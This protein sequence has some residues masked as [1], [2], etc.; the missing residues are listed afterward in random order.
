MGPKQGNYCYTLISLICLALFITISPVSPTSGQNSMVIE[1]KTNETQRISILVGKSSDTD[2][3]PM[4]DGDP[5]AEG[6][7]DGN[8]VDQAP[9]TG[10]DYCQMGNRCCYQFT[11]QGYVQEVPT[12]AANTTCEYLRAE[13]KAPDMACFDPIV[14][15]RPD[16]GSNIA[17]GRGPDVVRLRN[18]AQENNW[19]IFCPLT[20]DKICLTLKYFSRGAGNQVANETRFC[21]SV[22]ETITGQK[23]SSGCWKENAPG[24]IREVCA[25]TNSLCN[26]GSPR[27]LGSSSLSWLLVVVSLI[28]RMISSQ[29]DV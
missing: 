25:C 18:D 27:S 9:S 10:W 14:Y 21:G 11:W 22:T 20:D 1:S 16:E 23:K 4:A 28:L 29:S 6:D 5:P 24:Y 26:T 7:E 19:N 15:T 8:I 13:K 17:N 12:E 3:G 2:I